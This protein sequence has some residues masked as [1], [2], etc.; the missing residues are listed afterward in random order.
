[1]T[2]LKKKEKEKRKKENENKIKLY[3][4][5]LS[6]M[7]N[8]YFYSFLPSLSTLTYILVL[9]PFVTV[10][11][12]MLNFNLFTVDSLCCCIHITC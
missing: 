6:K 3:S 5:L 2:N 8:L 12:L 10:Y 9:F 1:M 4:S 7:F 11:I